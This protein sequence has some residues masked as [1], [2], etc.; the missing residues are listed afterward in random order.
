M[1]G[2][3]MAGGKGSRMNLSQ[4]KLLLEY[5]KPV[6]LHVIDTLH[7]SRCFSKVLVVTS[8]NS[9]QTKNLIERKYDTIT[10]SGEGFVK[11]LNYT[12]SSLDGPV[13]VTPGD[14]PLLDEDIIKQITSYYNN[15]NWLSI[16]VTKK[17]AN[18]L[19]LSPGYDV[20]YNDKSC[21]YTGISMVNASLISDITVLSEDYKIL[22]D[23]RIAFNL[24]TIQDYNL[25]Y[26]T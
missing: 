25:L 1:I 9:P 15:T 3:V 5:K 13:F 20:S 6:I 8:P 10:T 17:F 19:N 16:L 22:D 14:L 21:Y 12:L 7:N 23:K 4:E 2:V 11:D 18:S 26:S 24:N